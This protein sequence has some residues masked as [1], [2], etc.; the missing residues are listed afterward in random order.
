[1]VGKI[2]LWGHVVQDFYFGG[3][4]DYYFSFISCNLSINIFWFFPA[5]I[6]K[7]CMFLQIYPF[8]VDCPICWHIVVCN[9][10]LLCLVILWCWLLL[11]FSHF[12]L[13]LFGFFIFLT[14]C[15]WLNIC[16]SS[17]SFQRIHS[18]VPYFSYHVLDSISFISSVWS[19]FL[20]GTHFGLC[21]SFSSSFKCEVRLFILTLYCFLR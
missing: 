14:W 4:F 17:L 13:Y 10:F 7:D 2:H 18:W 16:V 11:L 19:Y 1:M 8:H 6:F 15:V 21:F 20:P 3:V 12:W 9:I 5:S